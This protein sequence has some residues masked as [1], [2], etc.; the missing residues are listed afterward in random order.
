MRMSE[1]LGMKPI[2]NGQMYRQMFEAEVQLVNSLVN[3]KAT[4]RQRRMQSQEMCKKI[5]SDKP[6]VSNAMTG[7][8]ERQKTW[9]TSMPNDWKTENPVLRRYFYKLISLSIIFH[10]RK[11]LCSND[12][13][14][15]FSNELSK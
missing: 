11:S 5:E 4:R 1:T 12:L 9:A 13:S 3:S 7:L 8:D 10:A 6:V 2:P 15:G 14:S